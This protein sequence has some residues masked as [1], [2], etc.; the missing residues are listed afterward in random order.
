MTVTPSMA[1]SLDFL[2]KDRRLVLAGQASIV[3]GMGTAHERLL[4]S[5]KLLS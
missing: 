3:G 5:V 1:H 4:Y 2:K